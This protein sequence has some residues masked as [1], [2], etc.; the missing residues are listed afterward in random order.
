MAETF[1]EFEKYANELS[2]EELVK[3]AYEIKKWAYDTRDY[4]DKRY[5]RLEE[6]LDD[7]E[8]LQRKK[9]FYFR[10]TVKLQQK[11]EELLKEAK[12]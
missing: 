1:E 10:Q 12:K 8:K 3:E 2:R 11:I 7:N 5:E 9:E 6:L 4:Q